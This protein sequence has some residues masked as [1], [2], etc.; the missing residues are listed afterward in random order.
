LK[1]S[2][3]LK[4]LPPETILSASA[5]SS[6]SD[7]ITTSFTIV[8]KSAAEIFKEL[9]SIFS[10]SGFTGFPFIALKTFGLNVRRILSELNLIFT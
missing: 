7:A 2:G 9:I 4:P 10:I 8:L 5:T 3:P 6:F 1:C